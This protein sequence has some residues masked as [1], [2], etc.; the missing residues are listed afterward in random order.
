MDSKAKVV[1]AIDAESIVAFE[2][3][4]NNDAKS[5][6]AE[7]I[8]ARANLKDVA[9]NRKVA[10]ESIHTY[11]H[12]VPEVKPSVNQ[13]SSGR[14]WIFAALN[15]IREQLVRDLKMESFELSQSYVFFW[16]KFEKAGWFLEQIIQ[17]LDE[18]V[19]DRLI[20]YLLKSPVN[21]GGQYDMFIN[22]VNKYGLVPKDVY[23]DSTSAKLS[24]PMNWIITCKLREFAKDLRKCHK[25]GNTI[26][27][28]RKLKNEQLSII[29]R[30]LCINLGQP[31]KK[32]DFV[33]KDKDK[34]FHRIRDLS[35]K[36]FVKD[37]VTFDVNS[38]VSLINDPRNPYYKLYTVDRLGN[39]VGGRGVR[40]LNLPIEELKKYAIKTIQ[41]KQ[42]VWFGCDVGKFFHR[43][44]GVM[45]LEY[46]SYDKMFGIQ[47]S[48][49]SKADRLRYGES[50]MTHAMVFTGVELDH[51]QKPL[52][53]RVQN[54]WGEKGGDKGYLRM[55]DKWFDEYNY[56]ISVDKSILSED[57]LKVLD[58]PPVKLPPWDPMGSL[59][60]C[61]GWSQTAG[62]K[63]SASIYSNL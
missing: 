49:F 56:Q 14:C 41:N 57:T 9:I 53:W 15:V 1:G 51:Q 46:F 44:D 31:P 11:S 27:Q 23:P 60:V 32:F 4:Y 40:Y 37:H 10:I 2:S 45:D 22:I 38:Q 42:P 48:S 12:T 6:L 55:S 50:L 16:D 59:A 54:S 17:T 7:D 36:H 43:D 34:K 29:Y 25:Q 8:L 63:P 58:L 5:K 33:Y 18:K 19:E 52:S 47:F 30:I 26:K 39:V 61:S 24:R 20:S 35:P 62:T 28:L 21:D 13:R 3:K